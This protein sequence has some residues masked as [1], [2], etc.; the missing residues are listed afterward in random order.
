MGTTNR[1]AIADLPGPQNMI[2]RASAEFHRRL[3]PC[4]RCAG[5]L[6]RAGQFFWQLRDVGQP[7]RKLGRELFVD[8]KQRQT[9]VG[10]QKNHERYIRSGMR[11]AR[12]V[13]PPGDA[14]HRLRVIRS[15]TTRRSTAA[16]AANAIPAST[17]ARSFRIS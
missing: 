10:F 5:R 6:D 14:H 8:L 12:S 2:W 7:D 15:S 3:P 1:I 4:R 9:A 16:F 17:L 13:E 11:A